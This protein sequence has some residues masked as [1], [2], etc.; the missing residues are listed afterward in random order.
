M[1]LYRVNSEHDRHSF[2]DTIPCLTV[3]IV[4]SKVGCWR[5][6]TFVEFLAGLQVYLPPQPFN[7]PKTVTHYNVVCVQGREGW[8]SSWGDLQAHDLH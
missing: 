1:T 6:V 8:V 3:P 2:D 4:L 7:V 5:K